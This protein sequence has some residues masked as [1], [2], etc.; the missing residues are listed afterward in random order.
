[1]ADP[2][3]NSEAIDRSW[4]P[5]YV[6]YTEMI[7][8]N[9]A[10]KGLFYERGKDGRVKWVV[11]GKSA[12]G[13]KRQ[14]WWDAKCKELGIPIQK[15]CYAI[16]ARAI[17]PTKR[18]VCQ[19]CGRSLS[20]EYEYPTKNTL[21]KINELLGLEL[22]QTDYTIGEIIET[23]CDNPEC[24]K[25]MCDILHIPIFTNK[26]S[27]V[28]Y[29]YTNLVAKQSGMLSPGAMSNP[30][31]RFEGYH[32]D[33]L[34]CREHTDKGRHADNMKTYTQDR[35]AFEEWSDGDYNLANRLMGEFHKDTNL[36]ECPIC[37]EQKRVSA[38]HIGPISLGFCHSKFFAPLCSSCN[39]SKNN[40]FYKNDVDELIRL[41]NE[42]NTVISWHSKYVWDTLKNEVLNDAD[43][44]RLSLIMSRSHQSVLTLFSIIYEATGKEFLMR[45]LHPEY[46]MFDIRFENFDPTDL[47]KLVIL[48][49]ELDSKNKR[50]N[51][52]RYIRIAFESL[53][54]FKS[55]DNRRTII[56]LEPYATYIDK[57][58]Q[59]I[60]NGDQNTA[61]KYL[62]S[63]IDKIGD[64]IINTTWD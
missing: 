57:L 17:H 34:C 4:H 3:T 28:R 18:H 8:K 48:R 6:E 45:Y 61:D 42:G 33:G 10:Y 29:V 49:K 30:P 51:Q 44:K 7:V 11:T 16:A 27:A 12:N 35:R 19:C 14:A 32:S 64:D 50:K 25:I 31:D 5:N 9:P 59:M 13:K 22:E 41:E 60:M 55:K 38:D 53:E 15:G 52:D 21:S 24:L 58:I 2:K 40:R 36:Y 20:I 46:S 63:L 1:M 54:E 56:N 37:H 23:F 39:S 43:A 62:R 47:T 26:Q